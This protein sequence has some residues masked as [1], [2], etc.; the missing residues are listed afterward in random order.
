MSNKKVIKKERIEDFVVNS[1]KEMKNLGLSVARRVILL[2][3]D[4]ENAI[5]L[6]LQGGLGGGKTTFLQGFAQGLNIRQRVL[7]PTFVLMKR[8]SIPKKPGLGPY[9]FRDFYHIDCYRIKETKEML[10]LGFKEIISNPKNIVCVEW[11]DRIRNIMPPD[12][13]WIDFNF[14][15]KD[16]RKVRIRFPIK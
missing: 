9:K 15:T 1:A 13:I 7:S 2:R 14:L 10:R 16:K 11:A 3:K 12:T 6:G 5:V 4:K 8:F